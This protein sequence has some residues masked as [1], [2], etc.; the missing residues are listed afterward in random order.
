M[1]GRQTVSQSDYFY[2]K[3][4][5]YCEMIAMRA[6]VTKLPLRQ[7]NDQVGANA[8]A[9]QPRACKTYCPRRTPG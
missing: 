4:P 1:A 5:N 9:Q 3:H 8:L 6:L 7:H 2:F